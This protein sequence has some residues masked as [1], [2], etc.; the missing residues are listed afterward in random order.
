MC[1][2]ILPM[3]KSAKN[4]KWI[5]YVATFPPRE[6]GIATFT[7]DLTNSF[8]EMYEPREESKIIAMNPEETSR[9]IYDRKKVIYQISQSNEQ[10]YIDAAN[11]VNSLD[12]VS[13]VHLQHEFGIFGGPNGSHIVLFL[14]ALK[15]PAVVT[16]HT[17][18]PAPDAQ[19]SEVV[20][21]LIIMYKKL[22][23]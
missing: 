5:V 15:K 1:V 14:R 21:Q 23:S 16:F 13:L 11:Y 4:R 17:I 9:Y 10:S 2:I 8:N 6:C 20:G 7:Q 18:L 12:Q 22:L 19:L 3:F